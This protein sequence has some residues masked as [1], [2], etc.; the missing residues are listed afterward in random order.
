MESPLMKWI[1]DPV[2]WLDVIVKGA[3]LFGLYWGYILG[4]AYLN[5]SSVIVIQQ[6][7]APRKKGR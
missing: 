2:S 7:D 6:D 3:I 4:S 1:L 5:G